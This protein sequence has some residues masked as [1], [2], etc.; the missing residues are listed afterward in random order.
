[1][2][3]PINLVLMAGQGNMLGHHVCV[4]DLALKWRNVI[5]D[6]QIWHDGNWTPLGVG[7]GYQQDGYGPELSFAQGFLRGK[8]RQPGSLGIVKVA[9]PDASLHHDWDPSVGDG[10]FDRLVQQTRA[11]MRAGPVVLQGLIWLQGEADSKTPDHANAYK[12]RFGDF[13]TALRIALGKA[14]LPVISALID[15]P[16]ASHPFSGP[17]R[18]ALKS[19]GVAHCDSVSCATVAK[20]DA[21]AQ[22]SNRGISIIG[23]HFAARLT[24]MSR[25]PSREV[26]QWLWNSRDYQCWYCGPTIA[27]DQVVVSMPYASEQNGFSAPAFG[28][29]YLPK[30]GV[31]SVF[32]RAR[33]SDWF[34]TGEIFELTTRIRA[35]LGDQARIVVYGASMGGY[36]AFLT[37]GALA[38]EKVIAIAPQYSIDRADVPFETRWQWAIQRI[39]RFRHRLEDHISP[40]TNYY[41]F[42]D[43]ISLDRAQVA[44]LPDDENWHRVKLPLASHQ[45]LKQLLETGLLPLVLGGVFQDGPDIDM[46]VTKM[47]RARRQ[48]RLT[49][50][51]KS[52]PRRPRLALS[53]L[54]HCRDVGGPPRRIKSLRAKIEARLQQQEHLKQPTQ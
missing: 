31:A 40:D 15:P 28:Q 29:S 33:V 35:F 7:Q 19:P 13:V 32:I 23:R 8:N 51:H 4:D 42:Y 25:A 24:G 6:A 21:S 20:K 14:D 9:A 5:S 10:L 48:N 30:T 12:Q 2:S 45:V 3:E 26:R 22:Y 46:I 39:G 47:R 11:A 53:A 36:G 27:P 44:L 49:L 34:Q 43:P 18:Q 38:A 1:M 52:T 16:A 37:S 54:D 17:V 41:V 50:A